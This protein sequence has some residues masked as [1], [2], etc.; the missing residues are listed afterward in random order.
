MSG[1]KKGCDN[2]RSYYGH[3]LCDLISHD[4]HSGFYFKCSEKLLKCLDIDIG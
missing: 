2:I 4:N 3:C 1:G